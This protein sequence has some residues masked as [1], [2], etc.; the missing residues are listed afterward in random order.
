MMNPCCCSVPDCTLFLDDF[1]RADS[2]SLGA[3]WTE[4]AG[5]WSILSNNLYCVS[6][7][8]IA[9]Y[10]GS[11]SFVQNF[12]V[13]C[14]GNDSGDQMRLGFTQNIFPYGPSFIGVELEVGSSAKLRSIIDNGTKTIVWE[15]SVTAAAGVW[16]ELAIISSGGASGTCAVVLNR[17][18]FEMPVIGGSFKQVGTGNITS[19]VYFDDYQLGAGGSSTNYGTCSAPTVY[20]GWPPAYAEPAIITATIS[21]I[22]TPSRSYMNGTYALTYN[23]GSLRYE[24]YVNS[25]VGTVFLS[26]TDPYQYDFGLSHSGGSGSVVGFQRRWDMSQCGP[27]DPIQTTLA[28]VA[29]GSH[30]G[31]ATITR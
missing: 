28:L 18:R 4:T 16:H 14:K 21:G 11:F 1:N 7:N 23:S 13:L 26:L 9:T 10:G 22:T 8:A 12:R 27:D 19:H 30:N 17:S 2:G 6:S 20:W 24:L 5:T 31:T 3:N 15:N 29:S 25:T